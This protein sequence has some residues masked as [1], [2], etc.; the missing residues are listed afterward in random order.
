MGYQVCLAFRWQDSF[1]IKF[2][3]DLYVQTSR[4]SIWH[5]VLSYDLTFKNSLGMS[6]FSFV[7]FGGLSVVE[8]QST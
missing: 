6:F 5:E 8:R 2:K 3:Y 1:P 7:F 4:F